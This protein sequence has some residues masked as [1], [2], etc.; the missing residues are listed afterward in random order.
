SLRGLIAS[1][2]C[3][4]GR[5]AAVAV[6]LVAWLAGAATLGACGSTSERSDRSE[7]AERQTTTS[8][9]PRPPDPRP[10]GRGLAVGLTEQTA[11]LLWSSAERP[12]LPHGFGPWRDRVAALSPA[13]VRVLVDW[14]A[15]Q[16]DRAAPPDW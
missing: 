5:G 14:A 10:G 16:P 8:A 2:A 3:R 11:N 15:V 7:T 1:G 4:G 9:T 12:R 13:R 6:T